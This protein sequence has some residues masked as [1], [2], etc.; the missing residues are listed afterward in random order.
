MRLI[1]RTL[2]GWIAVLAV[3]VLLLFAT[4]AIAA[5]IA[6]QPAA[7]PGTVDKTVTS[8]DGTL[9]AYEQTGSGPPIILVAAALSDRS[10]SRRLAG[11]LAA[12]FTVINYDRRGRG[13]ST[14]S[15]PYAVDREIEDIQSL[16]DANG[17]KAILLGTSSGAVL[18]L[19]AANKLAGK[20]IGLYLYEPPLIVDNTW[21]PV[22][23]DLS[24][25]I[26]ALVSANR[27]DEAVKLFFAEAMGIPPPATTMMSLLMPGWD[28][29]TAM[30]HTLRYDLAVMSG[31]QSGKPLPAGRWN[32]V[33][34]P[35][36]VAAGSR[37]EPFFHNG[38]KA[39]AALLPAA[40][41]HS[42]DGLDHSAVLLG[43]KALAGS[44]NFP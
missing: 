16:I 44:V 41:Y 4:I 27:R 12:R 8:L 25:R 7:P 43:S 35:V 29:M 40:T 11:H 13:D 14:G 15:Q 10:V 18:A 37:S 30:A 9:I 5:R 22:P 39:L 19:E 6:F 20:G 17:G 38:A 36:I 1:P 3:C 32:S 24:D 33:T 2:K 23:A 28:K 34:I 31:L 26:A 42:L 21:P